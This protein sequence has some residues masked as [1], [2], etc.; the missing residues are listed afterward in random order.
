MSRRH[1]PIS[2]ALPVARIVS[3]SR[4]AIVLV[5]IASLP[6]GE[7]AATKDPFEQPIP[8]G[9]ANQGLGIDW[10][11]GDVSE[12]VLLAQRANK[13]LLLLWRSE[14]C[15]HSARYEATVL[16]SPEV[17][18]RIR[19]LIAV[20]VDVNSPMKA[21]YRDQF[22][23]RGTPTTLIMAPDGRELTRIPNALHPEIYPGLIDLTLASQVPIGDLA[24][25]ALGGEALSADEWW[26]LA[27]YPWR[28]DRGRALGNR[29]PTT[30]LGALA[31][32]CPDVAGLACD[33]LA[34]GHVYAVLR[35]ERNGSLD[36]EFRVGGFTHLMAML[37]DKARINAN[38]DRV[39]FGGWLVIPALTESGTLGRE[40]MSDR[41]RAALLTLAD[42]PQLSPI[43]QFAA[44][45]AMVQIVKL[46]SPDAGELAP[47]WESARGRVAR[48]VEASTD[49]DERKTL[50]R[51]GAG[52]LRVVGLPEEAE[53]L[54]E[55]NLV[56]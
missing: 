53:Q 44:Y 26:R 32:A 22:G 46:D 36:P 9:T 23:L 19:E 37:D 25:A 5:A 13:P 47:M 35:A 42:D 40:Q 27:A 30:S 38:F 7:T 12:A 54:V 14:A 2:G 4:A 39:V 21:V 24:D 1:K 34:T 56:D 43:E 49:S 33:R 18:D 31:S 16:N 41:W 11:N 48:A 3:C 50:V 10:H 51:F 45:A 29:D 28:Q 8:A 52:L 15:V 17:V 6:A 55:N 20:R